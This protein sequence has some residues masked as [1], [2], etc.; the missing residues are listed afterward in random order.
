LRPLT[1]KSSALSFKHDVTLFT[2]SF[3]W[4]QHQYENSKCAFCYS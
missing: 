4:S 3:I 2:C 1:Q